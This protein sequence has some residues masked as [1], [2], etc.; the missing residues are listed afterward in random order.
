MQ[1][2]NV[3]LRSD[4]SQTQADQLSQIEAQRQAYRE[5]MRKVQDDHR[6][7]VETLQSQLTRV[8]EQLYA[9]QS[10]NSKIQ[11]HIIYFI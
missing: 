8:E 5:Q 11:G 7:I 2:E 3:T 1:S 9:L 6:A 10:Q 4:L